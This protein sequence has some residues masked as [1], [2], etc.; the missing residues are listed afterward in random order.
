VYFSSIKAID[1]QGATSPELDIIIVICSL[2]NNHG[3]CNNS[4]VRENSTDHYQYAVC[5]CRSP[6]TG[7]YTNKLISYYIV[8]HGTLTRFSWIHYAVCWIVKYVD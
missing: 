3:V 8:L 7:E 6:W 4:Q 1:D 2:C 5:E